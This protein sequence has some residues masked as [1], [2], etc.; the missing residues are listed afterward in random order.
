MDGSVN[1]DAGNGELPGRQR[2][3][4]DRK[5]G[6]CV[7]E[8]QRQEQVVQDGARY[9]APWRAE[10]RHVGHGDLVG[11]AEIEQRAEPQLV[12]C[13]DRNHHHGGRYEHPRAPSPQSAPVTG[14]K[15]YVQMTPEQRERQHRGERECGP[16]P[17]RGGDA[18]GARSHVRPRE[19]AV[20]A[21]GT[22][23]QPQSPCRQQQRGREWNRIEI[24]AEPQV[25]CGCAD[26]IRHTGK[27]HS[28][29]RHGADD[30]LEHANHQ[31]ARTHRHAEHEQQFG[32]ACGQHHAAGHE[33]RR[34][35]T[36]RREQ[37]QRRQHTEIRVPVAVAERV[38]PVDRRD[39]LVEQTVALGHV[40]RVSC[41]C[42]L[43]RHRQVEPQP[44]MQQ[45]IGDMPILVKVVGV[46][47]VGME[48]QRRGKPDAPHHM[49][50]RIE[51]QGG[52]RKREEPPLPL[53]RRVQPG[54]PQP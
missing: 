15:P 52:E 41:L 21:F 37:Q 38:I 16:A 25:R 20:A 36:E 11:V 51:G 5:E 40:V 45:R 12:V 30:V 2:R 34:N 6:E 33:P 8:T 50:D 49:P 48:P 54:A 22:Q 23:P 35:H 24:G 32:A 4:T 9:I 17:Q 29:E 42:Q 43:L 3:R 14:M 7:R 27:H 13:Q 28:G 31:Q 47:A 19:R 1:D 18:C 46:A 10:A 53:A 26:Q 44:A 39:A